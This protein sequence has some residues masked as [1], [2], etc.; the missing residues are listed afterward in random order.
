MDI[1]NVS[2]SIQQ[3][4][5]VSQAHCVII[6]TVTYT[7]MCKNVTFNFWVDFILQLV[8]RQHSWNHTAHQMHG[9]RKRLEIC[10]GKGIGFTSGI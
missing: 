10:K 6:A 5:K 8:A 1:L 9:N 3:C 2:I 4:A 7:L